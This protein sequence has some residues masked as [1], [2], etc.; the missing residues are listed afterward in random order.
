MSTTAYQGLRCRFFIFSV[1]CRARF[2]WYL[3]SPSIQTFAGASFWSYSIILFHSTAEHIIHISI[4]RNHAAIQYAAHIQFAAIQ[5]TV[6]PQFAAI[7]VAG[8]PQFAAILAAI[9]AALFAALPYAAVL[10]RYSSLQ[11]SPHI[12][13]FRCA[14]V[15]CNAD[16][17][18]FRNMIIIPQSLISCCCG[19]RSP[20]GS[21]SAYR[22]DSQS[23]TRTSDSWSV[24]GLLNPWSSGLPDLRSKTPNHSYWIIN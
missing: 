8:H 9:L 24:T 6:H 15:C 22:T 3:Y 18:W 10:L 11:Y 1:G 19:A 12:L 16:Y 23:A 5:V 4:I 13:H 20:I 7:P 2:N 14:T 17:S 21:W